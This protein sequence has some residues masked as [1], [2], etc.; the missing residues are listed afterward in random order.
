MDLLEILRKNVKDGDTMDMERRMRLAQYLNGMTRPQAINAWKIIK[1]YKE[2][3]DSTHMIGEDSTSMPYYGQKSETGDVT[4]V[5]YNSS[6]DIFPV[7][8]QL[9]LERLM[10][11]Q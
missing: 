10:D 5:M 8:L 3:Y 9:I 2:K 1:G 11:L 7:E 4:F 6:G